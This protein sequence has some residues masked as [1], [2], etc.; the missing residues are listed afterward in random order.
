MAAREVS[1]LSPLTTLRLR[2]AAQSGQ[3]AVL[4]SRQTGERYA[5]RARRSPRAARRRL[6]LLDVRV[7]GARKQRGVPPALANDVAVTLS[8]RGALGGARPRRAGR[9]RGAAAAAVSGGVDVSGAVSAGAALALLAVAATLA[10]ARVGA[11]VVVTVIA[12]GLLG[13]LGA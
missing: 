4:F 8:R 3:P 2:L 10:R 7:G 11:T 1:A 13:D 5:D 12:L 9:R 6:V